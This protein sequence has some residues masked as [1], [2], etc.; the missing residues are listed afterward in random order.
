MKR[1][2]RSFITKIKDFF[3]YTIP[4]FFHGNKKVN[5]F[6]HIPLILFLIVLFLSSVFY[7]KWYYNWRGQ[8][9]QVFTQLKAFKHHILLETDKDYRRRYGDVGIG[10]KL[11]NFG[12]PSKIYDINDREIGEFSEER[13]IYIRLDQISPIFIKTLILTE[14][15]NFYNHHGVDYVAMIRAA[16]NTVIHFSRQ[17]GSGLTQQLSK[18][19]FT[20]REKS[21]KRKVFEMFCAKAIEKNHTKEEILLMY[22]NLIYLGHGANGVE[23]ASKIYFDKKSKN[24][25]IGEASFLSGIILNPTYFSPLRNK[26][27]AKSRHLRVLR[28]IYNKAPKLLNGKTPKQ[29]HREFWSTHVF[30]RNTVKPKFVFKSNYAPYIIETVRRELIKKLSAEELLRGGY[31]IYTTIDIDLQKAA[32]EELKRGINK[33]RNV[34]KRYP[35][36]KRNG[37]YKHF[38]GALISIDPK[39]SQIKTLVGG[40]NFTSKNQLNRVYQAKRQVG[41]AFKPIIYLSSIDL[42]AM[43]MY[44]LVNDRPLKMRVR[45]PTGRMQDWEVNN[46]MK[47]YMLDIPLYKALEISSNVA[48]VRVI[49]KIGMRRLQEIVTKALGIS[50]SEAE[51]RFPD[52]V[53]SLALGTSDMSPY[54]VARV[55]SAVANHGK[56]VKPYLI[57]RVTDSYG[58]V[59]FKV[60]TENHTDGELIVRHKEAIYIIREMMRRVV[61]GEHGTGRGTLKYCNFDYAGKTG[62]SQSHRDQWFVGYTNELCTVVWFGHDQNKKL[63]GSMYG[64]TVAGP[65]WGKFMKRATNYINF[66]SMKIPGGLNLVRLKVDKYNGLVARD[67]M[68]KGVETGIFIS[69]TEPG[70]YSDWKKERRKWNWID[71]KDVLKLE[72]QKQE[73]NSSGNGNSKKNK[74][75]PDE[76]RFENVPVDKPNENENSSLKKENKKDADKLKFN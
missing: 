14:D 29:I 31:K 25:T 39:T 38:E 55:Y 24:L 73:E 47:K 22:V 51:R 26:R 63:V 20:Q 60:N 30:N 11:K 12:F 76:I 19:L 53:W 64:G 32:I 68:K 58:N 62:S 49:R 34:L 72:K 66:T 7:I 42:E 21:L 46:G 27:V 33:W 1:L 44:S 16:Y 9:K 41:S 37:L 70:D 67:D 57:R 56:A 74:N 28:L 4:D 50:S 8:R 59:L 10:T 75:E 6:I 54:E 69:G 2:N 48:A 23:Y 15:S 36:F 61:R 43:T 18:L 45:G 17:G 3:T 40:Y 35:K 71:E 65:V 52:K 13:R 5:I